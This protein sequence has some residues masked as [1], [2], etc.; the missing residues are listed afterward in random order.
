[1]EAIHIHDLALVLAGLAIVM[2]PRA[3]ATY[4][5]IRK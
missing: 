3:I 2:I 1:M 4:L 5:A